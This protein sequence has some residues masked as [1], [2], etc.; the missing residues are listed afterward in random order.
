MQP[1]RTLPR[2]HQTAMSAADTV[3]LIMLLDRV[4]CTPMCAEHCACMISWVQAS[5]GQHPGNKLQDVP[6]LP[7]SC[8]HPCHLEH[9]LDSA[10]S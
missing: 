10:V 3:W 2:L 8:P 9:R 4:P 1:V 6:H 7:K 5:A